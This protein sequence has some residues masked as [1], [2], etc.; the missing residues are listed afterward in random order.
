VCHQAHFRVLKNRIMKDNTENKTKSPLPERYMVFSEEARLKLIEGVKLTYDAVCSTLS[1]KG[2]NVAVARQ[3]GAPI[4]VHDGVTVAREVKHPDPF[5]QMGINLV[6]EAAQKTNDE[7]GDGTTTSTLIAYELAKG[8]FDLITNKKVNPMILRTQLYAA[9]E[10][11][12]PYL[13]KLSK[14]AKTQKDLERVAT[15]SSAD[16]V[17]GQMVGE[18]VYKVGV[19]GLVAV[20]ESGGFDTYIK[21]TEGMTIDKGFSS[22]YFMT[23]P[24]RREAV[25]D[26][27]IIAIVDKPISTQRELVPLVESMIAVSKNIV[28]VGEVKGDALSILVTNKA[29]GNINALVIDPPGYGDNRRDYL[30]D[31]AVL[32]GATVFSQELGMDMEQFS[33]TFDKDWL[34]KA[35]KVIAT[36]KTTMFVRGNGK[37]KAIKAQ[38]DKIRKHLAKAE[39]QTERE[40][41]EERLAKFTTGVAVVRVGAKT[42]I[43]AREKLERVKDAVGAAT[44]AL[45]EGFVPGSGVTFMHL[46]EA[47]KEDTPGANLMR[48][49]L[50]QPLR[51]VMLNSGENNKLRLFGLIPSAIDNKVE[52]IKEMSGNTKSIGYNSLEG[53]IDNMERAGIIDPTKVIRLCLENGLGVAASILTTDTLIDLEDERKQI[54]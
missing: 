49:V 33:Q 28:I 31:L 42:E 30:E 41:L 54:Y 39:S 45:E 12:K 6:R 40:R 29:R 2:R 3:Y 20:E 16:P 4:I 44:A 13:K 34:G 53:R 7:A 32:T 26:K 8:G 35:D 52:E 27:P 38:I 37:P 10:D 50:E 18:A 43:E 1:P 24:D 5:V 9:L 21:Y 46:A 48:Y 23:N 47:I 19:D 36:K 25:V 15:I 14:P 17:I 11:I 51:K 22:P